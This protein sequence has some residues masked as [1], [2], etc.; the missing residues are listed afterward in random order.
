MPTVTIGEVPAAV[1]LTT[2]RGDTI[3]PFLFD[4]GDIDLSDRTFAAQVRANRDEDGDAVATWTIDDSAAA[5]GRL[6]L[7]LPDTEC[8]NLTTTDGRGRYYWDLQWI[9]TVDDATQTKTWVAGVVRVTG[10]VTVVA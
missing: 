1:D 8:A 2:R 10:D 3:G 6:T 5:S 4:F 9:K 7:E